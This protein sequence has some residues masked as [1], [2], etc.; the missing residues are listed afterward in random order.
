MRTSHVSSLRFVLVV[1]LALALPLSALYAQE[2]TEDTDIGVK[3]VLEDGDVVSAVFEGGVG[4]HLYAFYGSEGDVF[5]LSMTQSEEGALDPFLVV[6]GPNGEVIA[7]DDDSGEDVL[8]SAAIDGVELPADGVYFVLATSFIAIDNILVEIGETGESAE[9]GESYE[10]SISGITAPAEDVDPEAL[11]VNVSE[12]AVGDTLEAESSAEFPVVY[13]VFNGAAG[14]VVTVTAESDDI[15]TVLHV[16]APSGDRI[17]INDDDDVEGGLNSAVRDVE[18][19]EDGPYL[20]FATDVFFYDLAD[21][22]EAAS[23]T[24]GVVTVSLQ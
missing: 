14:D 2:A 7:S 3:A 13:F 10:L 8:F 21:E 20:I 22:A 5:S 11:L 17:A 9:E 12:I 23:Y 18:L 19:P 4:A 1:I 16:F 15:D 24:G 6:L